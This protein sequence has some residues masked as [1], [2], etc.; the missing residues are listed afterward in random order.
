MSPKTSKIKQKT[1]A[2]LVVVGGG[3]AG[4]AAA[5]TAAEH[6][7]KKIIVLEK[8]GAPGGNTAMA[9]GLF[10]CESPT[11]VRQRIVADKDALFKRAMDWARW[12]RVNPCIFRAFLN[13]S[14]DT[15]RW[16]EQMGL[17]F[18]VIAFFPNQEPRVEHVP[19]GR[20][21]HLTKVL[22]EKCRDSGVEL[23]L[24]ASGEKILAGENRRVN[25]ILTTHNNDKIEIDTKC[26]IIATGGFCG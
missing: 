20:G 23:L 5:L 2:D 17:E 26:V 13:K 12:S 1:E 6:G 10:A 22:A 24:H 16:L 18:N 21:A 11:Q 15:I 8:R 7:L 3:G 19:Q 14:G 25:G 4:L 9:T